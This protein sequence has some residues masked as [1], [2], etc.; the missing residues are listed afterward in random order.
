LFCI[1]RQHAFSCHCSRNICRVN[2]HGICR[3]EDGGRKQDQRY[4]FSSAEE[5]GKLE[6]FRGATHASS[7]FANPS[8]SFAARTFARISS[9]VI[10][11]TCIAI[12][13]DNNGNFRPRVSGPFSDH[14]T[15]SSASCSAR[16]FA[17]I[18]SN[19]VAGTCIAIASN[20]H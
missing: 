18:S 5:K 7:A 20:N 1:A 4:K 16:T 17:R 9:N 2:S 19:V 15:G 3:D 12:A 8:A 13:S 6:K 10:A 11:G 14:F